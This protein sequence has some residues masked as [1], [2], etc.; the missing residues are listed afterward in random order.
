MNIDLHTHSYGSPDGSLSVADYKIALQSGLNAIAV[1]DH[2]R[3][4]TA[5]HIQ[6]E[7]GDRIIVGQEITTSQGEIVG[8]F[9][10]ELVRPKQTAKATAVAI[11]KQ[12]GLVYIPHPFETVRKGLTQKVLD[13]IAELVDIIEVFNGRAFFQNKGPQAAT[14]ARVHGKQLAA[15]S[16]AHGKR[17]LGS[18]YTTIVKMPTS[19]NLVSQ[20]KVGRLI[21]DRPPLSS[22]L[23]PKLN[24]LHGKIRRKT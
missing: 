23:Y 9:L 2:D 6:E 20:L 5:L 8:L 13:E 14:W 7:L 12:G 4:D 10:S 17:G 11:H 15:S 19:E 16:D 21:T 18:C 1:T 22:L 24:R 3:I